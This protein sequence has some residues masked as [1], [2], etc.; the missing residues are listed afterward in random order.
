MLAWLVTRDMSKLNL[1]HQLQLIFAQLSDNSF[2]L[3]YERP[4]TS[5]LD[6]LLIANYLVFLNF[7]NFLSKQNCPLSF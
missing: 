6:F 3:Y 7:N 1:Q 5:V 4:I 2:Q